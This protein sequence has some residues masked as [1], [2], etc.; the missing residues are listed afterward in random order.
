VSSPVFRPA[1]ALPPA[2]S[3]SRAGKR[4]ADFGAA[5]T[6][7]VCDCAWR[8]SHRRVARKKLGGAVL[9]N[10]AQAP[11]TR[12]VSTGLP[13][14]ISRPRSR[15]SLVIP[16]A[17]WRHAF[18]SFNM[19]SMPHTGKLRRVSSRHSPSPPA[20][21][22]ASGGTRVSTPSARLPAALPDSTRLFRV[23]ARGG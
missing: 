9:R 19:N 22:R 16:S 3:S 20:S 11:R 2:Q 23:R 13:S 18:E 17:S 15:I 1:R 12:D 10:R 5:M 4:T 8:R 21:P 6:M 7:R 14:A